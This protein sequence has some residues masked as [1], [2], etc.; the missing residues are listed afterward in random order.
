MIVGVA[1]GIVFAMIAS[2]ITHE[3]LHLCGIMP[4]IHKPLFDTELVT[5]ELIYHSIYVI[6]GAV[7]TARIAKEHTRK[8]TFLMGSKEAIMWLLGVALLWN[9][10]FAWYNLT[11]AGLG[12]PL[13]LFGGFLYTKLFRKSPGTQK[14][15]GQ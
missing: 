15:P 10:T 1:A 7:I 12:I 5:I 6:V 13:A 3:I 9:H 2:I 11:K 14:V 4:A 8:A